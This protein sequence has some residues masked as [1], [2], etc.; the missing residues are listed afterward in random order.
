[1]PEGKETQPTVPPTPGAPTVDV[2]RLADAVLRL[3]HVELRLD[4]IRSNGG[5]RPQKG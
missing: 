3:M 4:H 2:E 1:M 5:V